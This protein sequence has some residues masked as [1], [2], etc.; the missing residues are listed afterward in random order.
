MSVPCALTIAGSDSSGGAGVQAD[1]KTF[2]ALGVFG[3]CVITA[4]T[5]QNTMGV[6][7]IFQIPSEFVARQIDAIVTDITVNATKTGMLSTAEV[8]EVVAHKVKEHSLTP[9]VVDPV[10]VASTGAPLLESDAIELLKQR[11]LPL[12]TVLTPN[13]PEATTLT[14]REIA[15]IRDMEIAAQALHD[16]GA[17]VVVI[18]GGHLEGEHAIDIVYDGD[19]LLRL[20][21]KRS[22]Q[23][24]THG[25][26]CIFS[27][28]IAADLAKGATAL[29]A[30]ETAKAFTATA[31]E[32]GMEIGRGIGPADPLV[33][34][35]RSH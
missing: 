21:Y 7:G 8:V 6:H 2:S 20:S 31:I 34:R 24:H 18:K 17:Q 23:R 14:G 5:A 11:L 12:A 13:I 33:W 15:S 25:T 26:G 9:L 16:A 4:L 29:D 30:I 27:A 10:M 1:L 3:T 19:K 28:A 35:Y 32:H 22:S